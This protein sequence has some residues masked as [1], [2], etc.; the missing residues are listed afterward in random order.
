V[1][2]ERLHHAGLGA[3]GWSPV[4]EMQFADYIFPAFDQIVNELAKYRARTG[5]QLDAGPITIRAPCS[6]VSSARARPPR[7]A[8]P[9][10]RVLYADDERGCPHTPLYLGLAVTTVTVTE[11]ARHVCTLWLLLPGRLPACLPVP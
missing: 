6:S 8:P 11:S 1:L 4:V 5:G 7:P 2:T 3:T 10:P 9:R